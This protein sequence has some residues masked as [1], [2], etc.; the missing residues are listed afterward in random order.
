MALHGPVCAGGAAVAGAGR[1]APWGSGLDSS[2]R[3]VGTESAALTLTW[4]IGGRDR[5]G[6]PEATQAARKRIRA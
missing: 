3:E 1:L 4:G 5:S 2:K 6:V